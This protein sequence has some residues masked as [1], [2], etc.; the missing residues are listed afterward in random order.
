MLNTRLLKSQILA[1]SLLI[2]AYVFSGAGCAKIADPQPPE[3]RIPQRAVDLAVRQQSDFI[4]LTV[5]KPDLNTDGSPVLTLQR[6]DVFRLIDDT[7]AGR[8]DQPLS[9]EQFIHRATRIQ[10]IASPQFSE[11]LQDKT[12]VVRDGIQLPEGSWKQ[13]TIRYAVRFV[14]KKKQSAGLSNQVVIT[15]MPI[16]PPPEDISAEVTEEYIRLKWVAPPANMDGSKPAQI[17]GYNIYRSDD[18]GKIPSTKINSDPVQKPEFED[19]NF[20]PGKTYYYAVG[21]IGSAQHPYAESLPSKT[22]TVSA[23]DVFPPAP[24]ADFNT[25]P[26]SGSVLLIWSPSSSRDVAGYK[27]Y[28]QEK[29]SKTRRILNSELITEFSFRDTSA[30][31]G[32]NWV[33]IIQAVDTFGNE[34]NEVRSELEIH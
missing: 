27:V 23:Q 24:P 18:A 22:H 31:P 16:P 28:R 32:K 1:V 19:R 12:F 21:T 10:S 25:L 5:S 30:D 26:D 34:S 7:G 15:P 17:A 8:D 29:G 2:T 3:I 4:I 6:V 33:Y 20:Q 13:Q 14:N 9:E 11:Y